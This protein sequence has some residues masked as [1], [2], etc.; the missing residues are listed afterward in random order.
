MKYLK[1]FEIFATNPNP[2]LDDLKKLLSHL[3]EMFK[4]LGYYHL[5]KYDEFE[6]VNNFFSNKIGLFSHLDRGHPGHNCFDING[7]FSNS[8]IF[9]SITER[10]GSTNDD[11]ANFIPEYFKTIKGLKLHSEDNM[12]FQVNFEVV[13]NVD[14]I[15][16][17]I[18][19]EDFKQKLQ[20]KKYNI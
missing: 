10:I 12:F 3:V 7:E 11:L 14:N 9:L 4:E 8:L 6:Y 16:N 1:K 17:K 19:I 15:I 2:R 5:P 20:L 18:S 13:D